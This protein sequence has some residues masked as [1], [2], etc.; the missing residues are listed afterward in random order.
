MAWISGGR[1]FTGSYEAAR[2]A[3]RDPNNRRDP[4]DR[5]LQWAA[6]AVVVAVV[7]AIVAF[8]IF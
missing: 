6:I 1:V 2:R 7:I 5:P 3:Q 4:S 8:N